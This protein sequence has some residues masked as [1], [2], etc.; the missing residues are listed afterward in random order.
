MERRWRGLNVE[1]GIVIVVVR[2]GV[3]VT[4]KISGDDVIK[5]TGQGQG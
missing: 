3:V 5:P 2:L 4:E 1:E